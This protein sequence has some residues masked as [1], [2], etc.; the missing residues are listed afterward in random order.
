MIRDNILGYLPYSLKV[1]I[2]TPTE[3]RI[4]G[5]KSVEYVGNKPTFEFDSLT[6]VFNSS[7]GALILPILRPLTDLIVPMVYR[8]RSVI[9]IIEL[10]KIAF[11]NENWFLWEGIAVCT[12]EGKP[13]KLKG[14]FSYEESEDYFRHTLKEGA[15]KHLCALYELF[16]ELKIDYKGLIDDEEA[17][18]VFDP[19]LNPYLV[20]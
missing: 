10:A 12:E 5:I 1:Y 6:P 18:S 14:K 19:R 13:S 9:P 4:V 15:V 11:P 7:S 17:L 2:K 16:H 20:Y 8:D 3:S